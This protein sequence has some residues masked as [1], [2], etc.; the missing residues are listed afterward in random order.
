MSNF[1][2]HC[3]VCY[4][5]EDLPSDQKGD[6]EHCCSANSIRFKQLCVEPNVSG[7]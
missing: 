2:A 4:Y 3:I 5:I 1:F 7:C 6:G